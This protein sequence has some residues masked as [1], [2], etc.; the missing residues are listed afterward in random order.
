MFPPL[1]LPDYRC[2]VFERRVDV[3]DRAVGARLLIALNYR[4][5]RSELHHVHWTASRSWPKL[6]DG[7]KNLCAFRFVR[8]PDRRGDRNE[9][10]DVL[11]FRV[12]IDRHPLHSPHQSLAKWCGRGTADECRRPRRR[13]DGNRE[14]KHGRRAEQASSQK[15]F[16][17]SMLPVGVNYET[18]R[19]AGGI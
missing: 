15:S 10:Q 17:R 4:V 13:R 19:I 6:V 2:D 12:A 14:Q 1:L 9:F 18:G 11:C 7:R 5:V 3:H 8:H 16:H